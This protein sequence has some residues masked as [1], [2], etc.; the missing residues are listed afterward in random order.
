MQS[1]L[2]DQDITLTFDLVPTGM[3]VQSIEMEV[4]DHEG[5][6]L[7]AK[8]PIGAFVAA[9][10]TVAAIVLATFNDLDATEN[11]A[12]R[13]I[14]LYLTGTG[15]AA[16]IALLSAS[17]RLVHEDRLPVPEASFQTLAGADMVAEDMVNLS[18]WA[19][20]T[21]QAKVSALME[22]R[23]QIAA[24]RYHYVPDD[25]QSR[26]TAVVDCPDLD[27]LSAN[28]FAQLDAAFRAALRRAQVLQADEFLARGASADAA[29]QDAGVVSIVIGESS[30]TYSRTRT[31]AQSRAV[32]SRAL[33]VLSRFLAAPRVGRA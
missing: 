29:Y 32:G 2:A 31:A 8:A 25:W 23:H 17:Y 10:P 9:S 27:G 3:S 4:V 21:D 15:L 5:V 24:M 13:T 1:F 30:R 12:A 33:S 11:A 26:V 16:G 19:T 7:S 18:A 14:N 20:A 28:E 22:S 6:V